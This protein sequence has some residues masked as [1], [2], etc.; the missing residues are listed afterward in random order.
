MYVSLSSL[1]H[2]C[3]LELAPYFKQAVAAGSLDQFLP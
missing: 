1:R 2:L 3:L